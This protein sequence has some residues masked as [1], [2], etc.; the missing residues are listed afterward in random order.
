MA[1]KV[2]GTALGQSF[3]YYKVLD[4]FH[5]YLAT[6]DMDAATVV[7]PIRIEQVLFPV[8]QVTAAEEQR[9]AD[10]YEDLERFIMRAIV[11]LGIHRVDDIGTFYGLDTPLVRDVISKL[12]LSKHLTGSPDSAVYVSPI[13]QKSLDENVLYVVNGSKILRFDAFSFQPLP[14]RL[15]G[16]SLIRDVQGNRGVREFAHFTSWDMDNDSAV[17]KLLTNLERAELNVPDEVVSLKADDDSV[18]IGYLR[19]C[20]L[21]VLYDGVAKTHFY[22]TE[23]HREP[24]VERIMA[25]HT[26]VVDYLLG[27]YPNDIDK[28]IVALALKQEWGIDENAFILRRDT[29]GY[30]A[31]MPPNAIAAYH[32]KANLRRPL[33][34]RDNLVGKYVFA[35]SHVIRLWSDDL[36]VRHDEACR[37]LAHKLDY[38]SSERDERMAKKKGYTSVDDLI[39]ASVQRYIEATIRLFEIDELSLKQVRQIARDHYLITAEKNLDTFDTAGASDGTV[40]HAS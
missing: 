2:S 38:V 28:A 7:R 29:D 10:T 33:D 9:L 5:T 27:A 16:Y 17:D 30:T 36:D 25:T 39:T 14:R 22:T 1:A 32:S 18:E 24:F 35:R 40:Q 11:T 12:V 8:Y 23:T 4:N 13:G 26:D 21:R 34:T 6:A 3:R 15:Y 20:L 37:Y 31:T 19:L